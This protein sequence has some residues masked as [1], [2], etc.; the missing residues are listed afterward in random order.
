MASPSPLDRRR[1]VRLSA[2]SLAAVAAG[3]GRVEN[4]GYSRGSTIIVGVPGSDSQVLNPTPHSD[5]PFWLVFLPLMALNERGELEGRLA[6]R[7][8]LSPDYWERTYYLRPG[9]RWHDGVPVTAQDIKFSIELLNNPDVLEF[10]ELLSV[11]VLNDQTVKIRFRSSSYYELREIQ[12]PKH[13][14]ELLDTKQFWNWDFWKH[15]VGNGPYRVVRHVPETMMEFEVN[16][17]YYGGRPS[18]ERVVVKF[19]GGAGLTALL[20]GEVDAISRIDPAWIPTLAADARFQLYHSPSSTYAGLFW[21]HRDPL[22]RDARVR[23]A[24]TLAIDRRGLLQLARFP[25]DSPLADGPMTE[26][27]FRRGEFDES[28]PYDPEQARALLEAAGWHDRNGL[29][30]REGLAFRFTALVPQSSFYQK[31]AVYIQAQLRR[32]GVEMDVQM[33]ADVVGRIRSGEFQ[34]AFDRADF[35]HLTYT[36]SGGDSFEFAG[37]YQNAR[38]IELVKRAET[39]ANPDVQDQIYTDL[40]V[41]FREDVPLTYLIPFT[42]FSVAH[43][44]IR[45]LSSPWRI[46]PLRF[47]EDLWLEEERGS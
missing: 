15:P 47:M 38:V 31:M 22:F 29:R 19:V 42:R 11:T 12:Y 2:G 4:R 14:L 3:C 25:G 34:A 45:G 30:E 16:P 44:S 9:V 1:F 37:S 39:T 33:R 17:D 28:L 18:I 36:L 13:L 26:R 20:A 23:R 6:E 43:R 40:R 21:Q 46:D 35:G 41:I 7:W 5:H 27:Q 10:G 8:E 32:V 24:L